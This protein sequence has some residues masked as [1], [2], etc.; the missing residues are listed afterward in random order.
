[1]SEVVNSLIKAGLSR[2][3]SHAM[4]GSLGGMRGSDLKAVTTARPKPGDTGWTR[5][6]PADGLDLV[7]QA[8]VGDLLM[9]SLNAR[10]ESGVGWLHLEVGTVVGQQVVSY[11]SGSGA[12]GEGAVGWQTPNSDTSFSPISG[13]LFY[14]VKDEDLGA[15]GTVRLRLLG[16]STTNN[17][18][19]INAAAGDACVFTGVNLGSA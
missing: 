7:L 15:D 6:D 5:L 8:A 18:R 4:T 19:T 13:A 9:V 11:C 2:R 17:L 12:A 3:E 14:V 1:M 16:R 10:A